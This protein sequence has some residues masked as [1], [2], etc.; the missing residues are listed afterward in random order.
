MLPSFLEYALGHAP[1][2]HEEWMDRIKNSLG[3]LKAP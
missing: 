3:Y 1:L 2:L